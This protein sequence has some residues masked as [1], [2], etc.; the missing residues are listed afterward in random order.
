LNARWE[1]RRRRVAELIKQRQPARELL[2]TYAAVAQ[3]QEQV[4]EHALDSHW[5]RVAKGDC[6]RLPY[7]SML[8]L[9][10][11]FQERLETG[12]TTVL[13][14]NARSLRSTSDGTQCDLLAACFA[15]R[16]LQGFAASIGC[17]ETPLAFFPRAF[18][19][20]VAEAI[21]THADAASGEQPSRTC[22]RC[23]WPPQL[24]VLKDDPDT[25]GRRLLICALCVTE[26]NF[27][28]T[29]CPAC[30]E[31]SPAQ[32]AY[33]ESDVWPHLRIEGCAACRVYTKEVD[34]RRDGRAV[35]LVDDIASVELDLWADLRGLRKIELNVL[36]L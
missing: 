27:P 31:T 25:K 10:R 3:A 11:E 5:A 4:Y 24:A 14:E 22:P 21:V 17:E 6:R 28:R 2:E 12:C 13:Q 36:G 26:W 23:A 1:R 15:R 33:Y 19:Q 20:A 9:F 7:E 34:L 16:D 32:L 8:P 29:T 35:P 18:L 30:G